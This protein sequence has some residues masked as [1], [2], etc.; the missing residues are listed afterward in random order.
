MVTYLSVNSVANKPFVIQYTRTSLNGRPLGQ[1]TLKKVSIII[2]QINL[3]T[4]TLSSR[5]SYLL[6]RISKLNIEKG[7]FWRNKSKVCPTPK[8]TELLDDQ[9]IIKAIIIQVFIITQ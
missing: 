7:C 3:L 4:E 6:L 2:E 1:F 5:G 9:N 8:D